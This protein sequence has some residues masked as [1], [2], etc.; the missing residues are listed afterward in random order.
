ML[1]KAKYVASAFALAVS[2][3][4][5][6]GCYVDSTPQPQYQPTQQ[7]PNYTPPPPQQSYAQ[8]PDQS[9]QQPPPDQNQGYDPNAQAEPPRDQAGTDVYVGDPNAEY[10]PEPP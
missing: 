5:A 3:L 1:S 7:Q 8:P 2:T 4:G 9:Y 10:A 6:T